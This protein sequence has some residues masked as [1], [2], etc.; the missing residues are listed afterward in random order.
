MIS[1]EGFSRPASRQPTKRKAVI[2][3]LRELFQAIAESLRG[4]RRSYTTGSIPRAIVLLAVPMI[5]EMAM[6][7]LSPSWIFSG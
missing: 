3:T 1:L 5:L 4:G 7:S 6:E 2:V